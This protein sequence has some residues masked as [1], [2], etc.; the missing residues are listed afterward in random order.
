MAAVILAGL[1][2]ALAWEILS[3]L[4]VRPALKVLAVAA[5]AIGGTGV[6]PLFHFVISPDAS[7]FH[8][9]YQ[10]SRFIGW[11]ETAVAS[12]AWR[13]LFGQTRRSVLLPIETFGFQYVL[14]GYHAVLS[15]FLL[16][17]LAL[18][19]IVAVP[20]A[21]RPVRA[22]LEFVLGVTVPLT[23]C[24]NA[25][26]FPLQGALVAAWK[27]RDW[28]TSGNRNFFYLAL[29]VA[30]GVLALLPALAGLGSGTRHIR[31]HLVPWEA[32]VP[33]KQF[34]MVYWPLLV[35]AALIPLAGLTRSLAGFFA[36]FFLGALLLT[37]ILNIDDRGYA[38]EFLRFN[39][40]L[41]WWGWIFTGGVFML[42]AYLLASSHRAFRIAACLVLVLV[43]F[44][45][46][47]IARVFVGHAKAF[48]AKFDGSKLYAGDL[49][50]RRMMQLLAE[51]PYGIVLEKLYEDRPN[52]TGIY[53][54]FA[55]KPS[56]MGIPWVLRVWKRDLTELP[57]LM[58]EIN[59]FY[60][61]SHP[62][63]AR[64]L[65]DRNIRYV[66]WSVRESEDTATWAAID[67][68]IS[69][70]FRWMELSEK[71]DRHIGLWIRR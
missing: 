22:R 67:N 51:A 59:S 48:S 61:G 1:V 57:S 47:D 37:E 62:N 42:S 64:F 60:A 7:G 63:A 15:G 13:A 53:G 23:L 35:L 36:A 66:V 32:H 8:N 28:L 49:G 6:A 17:F 14:G 33:L 12:D 56:L 31:L 45:V 30:I 38:G 34:F 71:S 54:S 65:D 40:A 24:A 69:D 19:I 3:L 68:S 39:A 46:V 55:L 16:L 44:F 52:D 11:F 2:L 20:Q 5:L 25:W 58:A 29:G 18:A 50:N 10:N 43:S 21:S 70:T 27:L 9:F 4:L 41:K 26:A